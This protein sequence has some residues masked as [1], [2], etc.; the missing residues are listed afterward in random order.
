MKQVKYINNYN[1]QQLQWTLPFIVLDCTKAVGRGE[2]VLVQCE[3]LHRISNTNI[4]ILNE[5][6]HPTR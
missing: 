5:D 1:T 6:L 4:D 3:C 2:R